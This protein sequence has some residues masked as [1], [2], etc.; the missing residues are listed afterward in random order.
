MPQRDMRAALGER[1]TGMR[2]ISRTTWRAG[3][4]AL[5][6]SALIAGV[7]AST[8]SSSAN[9]GPSGQ[10][11]VSSPAGQEPNSADDGQSGQGSVLSPAQPPGS[12]SGSGQVTSGGS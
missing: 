3:A 2:T 8:A 1:A 4:V 6:F 11:P 5:V 9:H 10:V 7:F 12:S